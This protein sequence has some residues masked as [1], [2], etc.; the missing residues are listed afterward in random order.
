MRFCFQFNANGDLIHWGGVPILLNGS[1]ARDPEV[2]TLVEKYR[3]GVLELTQKLI[4]HSKVLLEGNECRRIECNLGNMIADSYIHKRVTQ[5]VGPQWT[6][7]A[8]AIIQ[9]GGVRASTQAGNI[10]KF[11]LKTVL[12]FNNTL[13]LINIT[14][15]VLLQAFEHAVEHYTGDR[16]EFLQVS[17]A[18]IVYDMS[19][20]SG[21]RVE[22][23]EVRCAD[24]EI[25]SYSKLDTN[26]EYGLILSEFIYD[27][28]DGFNMFQVRLK[29][30]AVFYPLFLVPF[31]FP[32]K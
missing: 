12:P 15:A 28:G 7:A 23:V 25:P 10:T 9:G 4:G 13:V 21:H 5:Y 16:G 14:G 6:D 31:L 1:I 19:K 2:L 26:K 17:G 22:S 3:P 18:R 30:L 29:R 24:C 8:I 27:R 11:D 20:E 32:A